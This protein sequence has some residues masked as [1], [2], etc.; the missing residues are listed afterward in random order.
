MSSRTVIDLACGIIMG[1]NRCSQGRGLR[2]SQEGIE[3]AEPEAARHRR[4]AHQIGS[5]C[6]PCVAL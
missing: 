3:R 2:D 1:Q 5:G 4:V 6:R